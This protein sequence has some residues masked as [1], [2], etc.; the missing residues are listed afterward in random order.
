MA[1]QTDD[2]GNHE[3]RQEMPEAVVE[4]LGHQHIEHARG[5][6]PIKRA[7]HHLPQGRTE[8]R[9]ADAPAPYLQ[10]SPPH[11]ARHQPGQRRQCQQATQVEAEGGQWKLRRKRHAQQRHPGNRQQAE[12]ETAGAIQHHPRN[13]GRAQTVLD[14]EAIADR[15]GH[16]QRHAHRIAERVADERNQADLA[17][18]QRPA[19]GSQRKTVVQGHHRVAGY[20]QQCR[21]QQ[22]AVR[23]AV[24]VAAHLVVIRFMGQR[25]QRPQGEAQQGYRQQRPAEPAQQRQHVPSRHMDRPGFRGPLDFLLFHATTNSPASAL[26]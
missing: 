2:L 12:P 9:Q 10:R 8:R 5:Q 23:Q 19:D 17:P 20:S 13:L 7:H 22:T 3:D 24:H 21:Q 16:Q 4:L 18:R 1:D 25:V 6:T 26:V 15:P 14:V 11:T